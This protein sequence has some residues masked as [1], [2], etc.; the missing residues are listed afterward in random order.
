[1]TPAYEEMYLN[2]AMCAMGEMLDYA[3]HDCG[4]DGDLFFVGD[5]IYYYILF[6]IF[7]ILAFFVV[8]QVW[9]IIIN[10]VFIKEETDYAEKIL[11]RHGCRQAR[12]CMLRTVHI[13]Q[14]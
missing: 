2:D 13:L 9:N 8:S 3:V 1:M 4:C 14:Y 10:N 6:S 5:T 7:F 12:G 11:Q